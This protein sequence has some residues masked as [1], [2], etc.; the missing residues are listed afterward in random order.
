[1]HE[2]LVAECEAHL[3]NHPSSG[4]EEVVAHF[5]SQGRDAAF[6]RAPEDRPGRYVI[7]RGMSETSLWLERLLRSDRVEVEDPAKA[8]RKIVSSPEALTLLAADD[9]G[10]LVLRAA[11]LQRRSAGLD[12][13]RTLVEDPQALERD[14][15]RAL[16]GQHWIF[17]GRFVGEAAHRRL[18]PGD[19]LDIP[20]IRG[21]GAQA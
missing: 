14:L 20:L 16:E 4:A 12:L 15:Q 21:G 6:L 8:A 10:Q 17:G 7:P 2:W 11:E 1:M 13:L 3:R 5:R 19:E 9:Q 18:V